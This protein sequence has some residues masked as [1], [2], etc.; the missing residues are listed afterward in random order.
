[1]ARFFPVF[2]AS[3]LGFHALAGDTT[4]AVPPSKLFVFSDQQL[5]GYSEVFY[6]TQAVLLQAELRVPVTPDRK[7]SIATFFD[8]GM[9]RIRGAAPILDQFGNVVADYNN[10]LYHTDAGVGIR[11]DLPQLGF[12]SIRLDFARGRGG[13]HTSFGIGQSF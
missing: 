9:L 5:R 6:G 13:T 3:T 4:G 8:D 10:W 1:V 12:R 7:F 11:F 2:K